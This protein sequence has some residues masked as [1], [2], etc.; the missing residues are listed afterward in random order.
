MISLETSTSSS[1]AIVCGHNSVRTTGLLLILAPDLT[2]LFLCLLLSS[3]SVP[4]ESELL[5]EL[6]LSSG[7]R[8][9]ACLS[10]AE[11]FSAHFFFCFLDIFFFSFFRLRLL[12]DVSLLSCVSSPD[13]FPAFIFSSKSLSCLCFSSSTLDSLFSTTFTFFFFLVFLL[14]FLLWLMLSAPILESAKTSSL[15]HSFG[16]E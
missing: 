2:F 4:E 1:L 9:P 16:L 10:L 12:S 3:L 13:F 14:V 8:A 15:R 11:T 6:K 5:P 7:N